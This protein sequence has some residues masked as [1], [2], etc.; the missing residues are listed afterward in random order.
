MIRIAKGDR[1]YC[2]GFIQSLKDRVS[3]ND[4]RVEDAKTGMRLCARFR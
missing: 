3:E 2:E 1:A 4:R